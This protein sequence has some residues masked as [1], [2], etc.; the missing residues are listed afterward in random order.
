MKRTQTK[1][2]IIMMALAM[3]FF[4]TAMTNTAQAFKWDRDGNDRHHRP[5][6]FPSIGNSPALNPTVQ[7]LPEGGTVFVSGNKRAKIH[8]YVSPDNLV[9][10]HIIESRNSLVIIDTQDEEPWATE[11]RDYIDSLDKDIDRVILSHSHPDHTGGLRLA[12]YDIDDAVFYQS[13]LN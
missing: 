1:L 13:F 7:T 6:P 11:A 2:P 3:I 8:T 12:L 4:L 9:T 10:T 5:G